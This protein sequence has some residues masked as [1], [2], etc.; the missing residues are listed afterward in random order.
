[1]T[2]GL[3]DEK[4]IQMKRHTTSTRFLHALIAAGYI[5]ICLLAVGIMYLWFHEWQE[6]EALEAENKR[7][8]GFRQ[9]VYH[10]Y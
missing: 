4:K 7:I 9:E 2:C 1:M 6:L 8:N 10:I 5:L 3:L